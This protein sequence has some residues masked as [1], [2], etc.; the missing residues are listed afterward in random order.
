MLIFGNNYNGSTNAKLRNIY[1]N[2]SSLDGPLVFAQDYKSVEIDTLV[3]Y[4]PW[5]TP[6]NTSY[7]GRIRDFV[8]DSVGEVILRNIDVINININCLLQFYGSS[9][10]LNKPEKLI[11]SDIYWRMCT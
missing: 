8:G 2:D 10:E 7:F 3:L 4:S 1:F 6:G 11:V 5:N 9:E